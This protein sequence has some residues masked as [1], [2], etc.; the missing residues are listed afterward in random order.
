MYEMYSRN[1][2][3]SMYD[4]KE[5]K[6]HICIIDNL[7]DCEQPYQHIQLKGKKQYSISLSIYKTYI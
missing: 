4:T 3:L 5:N 7:P 1:V 2:R 6:D